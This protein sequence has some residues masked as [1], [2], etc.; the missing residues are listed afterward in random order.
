VENTDRLSQGCLAGP[1]QWFC[2][3]AEPHSVMK[4]GNGK[5][6]VRYLNQ[7][8]NNMSLIAVLTPLEKR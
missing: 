6:A 2:G 8:S 4:Y 1:S 3:S 5:K 7:E